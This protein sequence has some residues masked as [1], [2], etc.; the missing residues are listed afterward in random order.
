MIDKSNTDQAGF[1]LIETFVAIVVLMITVLGPMMLL[2]RALL[3]ARYIKDE[4]VAT[5]LAQ[6]GVELMIY[7]R[8][9]GLTASSLDPDSHSCQLYLD[10]NGEGYNCQR[11]GQPTIFTRTIE[12]D[13][14]F[15]E[16]KVEVTSSVTRSN[17]LT[18]REVASRSIIYV[19]SQ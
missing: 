11:A 6:E 17:L 9:N 12:I 7:Q 8:N 5:Y 1:T 18:G 2:S 16:N 19:I 14:S 10:Q 3:D 15:S 13:N 4:I